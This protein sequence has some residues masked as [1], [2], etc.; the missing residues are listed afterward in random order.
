MADDKKNTPDVAPPT[1]APSPTAEVAAVPEP[2][3]PNPVPTDAEAVM[4]E[5]EGQAA[6]FK[7]GEAVPDH[8]D[9]VIHTEM[10]G[11]ADPDAPKAEKEQE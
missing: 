2:L 6:L 8:V 3:A 11:P 10:E 4:L 1:E 5:H 9:A 7:M